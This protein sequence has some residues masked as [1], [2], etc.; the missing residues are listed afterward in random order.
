[1]WDIEKRLRLVF[2]ELKQYKISITKMLEHSKSDPKNLGKIKGLEETK[3]E[4]LKKKVFRNI[5]DFIKDKGC[6]ENSEVFKEV[7]INDL[8]L[9]IIFPFLLAFQ[10]ATQ[11]GLCLYWEKE[12]M[13]A[14]TKTRGY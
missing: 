4:N 6:Q 1:M 8:V 3:I 2:T 7:N 11:E 13:S 10:H 14:N 5:T 12:I 9:F